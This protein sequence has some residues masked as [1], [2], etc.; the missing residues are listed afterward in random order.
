MYDRVTKRLACRE[1]AA[2]LGLYMG[3]YLTVVFGPA[4]IVLGLGLWNPLPIL[5]GLLLVRLFFLCLQL[6]ADVMEEIRV[7]E[8]RAGLFGSRPADEKGRKE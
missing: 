2:L 7:S 4:L 1:N 5:G 6:Q 3:Q 8:R